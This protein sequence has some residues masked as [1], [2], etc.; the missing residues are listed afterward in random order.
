MEGKK[1][2][3]KASWRRVKKAEAARG[4]AATTSLLLL[5]LADELT[6][7]IPSAGPD[8]ERGFSAK[9]NC[10]EPIP[11]IYPGRVHRAGTETARLFVHLKFAEAFP[12]FLRDRLFLQEV[13]IPGR[14]VPFDLLIPLFP[15]PLGEP[16]AQMDV[17]LFGEG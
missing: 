2:G 1:R 7:M 17:I 14:R 16:F 8:V 6:Q 12:V 13:E 11:P 3:E 4:P 5:R 15:V 9:R 10:H